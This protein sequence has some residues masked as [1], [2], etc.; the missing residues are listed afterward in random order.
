MPDAAIAALLNRCG[1]RT[2]K[3]HTWTE[4]RVRSFRGDHQIL[5][6]REGERAERGELTLDEAAQVLTVSDMTVLRMIQRGILPARQLC[7]GAPWVIRA[8]DLELEAVGVAVL[9]GSRRPPTADSRQ[10]SFE[11]Q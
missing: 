9:G 1:R 7:K 11:F 2:G 5:V 6:Y 8:T 10:I 4:S 3:G